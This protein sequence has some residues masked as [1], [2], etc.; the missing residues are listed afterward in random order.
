M[1]RTG[2]VVVGA[3]ITGLA[4]AHELARRGVEHVV[5]EAEDRPGGVIRS[6]RVEGKV[7]EI[8]PQR[9]RRV[10]PVDRLVEQL[11]LEGELLEASDDLP[12]YV[13]A[14]GDLRR[15]PMSVGQLVRTDLLSLR[16]KLRMALE[17]LSRGIRPGETVADFVIRKLGREAHDRLVGPLYGGIYGSDTRDMLV[18]HSLGR[19][20]TRIGA[21]DRSLAVTGLRWIL[22]GAETPAACSFRDGMETLPRALYRAHADR[23]LLGEPVGDA[24]LSERGREW[25]VAAQSGSWLADDVVLTV[26]SREA[27]RLTRQAFPGL[28]GRLDRFAYNPIVTVHLEGDC[29]LRGMGY[30]IA[31]GEDFASRGATWNESLFGR[32]GVH[33]AYLGGAGR[34]DLW[35]AP[36][37]ELARIARRE[38]ERVTGCVTRPLNVARVR[39]PAWDRTWRVHDE[40][41]LPTGLHLCA[42]YVS[43]AG[44]PGRLEAARGLAEALAHRSVDAGSGLG[45]GVGPG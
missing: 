8:G 45:T 38:F 39:M 33:T 7:L 18:E 22:K 25:R 5:L 32:D 43:R 29:G 23:I 15:V 28:A 21:A 14:D 2:V 10:P 1:K 24:S 16:G 3:G 12:L 34:E 35:E 42:A 17:P 9:T 6:V 41:E 13:Y 11:D 4:L 19:A 31:L 36:D 37:D 40:I 27:A 30:Q 44:I 20:L 26:P